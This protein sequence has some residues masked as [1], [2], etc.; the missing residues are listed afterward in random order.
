MVFDVDA[1]IMV[2]KQRQAIIELYWN[3]KVGDFFPL[4][5]CWVSLMG[6]YRHR[7]CVRAPSN[8]VKSL[9]FYIDAGGVWL[10]SKVL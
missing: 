9:L 10:G 1:Y 3:V 4:Y 5:F 6:Q 7:Y 8:V 2:G